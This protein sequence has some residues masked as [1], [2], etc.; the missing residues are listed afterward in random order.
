MSSFGAVDIDNF[1]AESTGL[2]TYDCNPLNNDTSF[3]G[4]INHIDKKSIKLSFCA[5]L[6]MSEESR[7]NLSEI[8]VHLRAVGYEHHFSRYDYDT[9]ESYFLDDH[10]C[11]SFFPKSL[12]F[13]HNDYFEGVKSSLENFVATSAFRNISTLASLPSGVNGSVKPPKITVA[14]TNYNYEQYLE[15]T[16]RS[17]LD[18]NYP[19]V[20]RIIVDDASTDDSGAVIAKYEALFQVV[21]H[22][23]NSGQLAAFFSALAIADGEFTL[24][25]DADDMLDFHAINAHLSVHLYSKPYVAFTCGR[26]RQMSSEG[27]MLSDYHLDLQTHAEKIKYVKPRFMHSPTWSWSTTSAMMFR[28]DMLRLIKTDKTEYFRI[29]ADYYIVNFSNLLGASMIFDTTVSSYRRHGKN[30]FSKNFIIGGHKPTGHMKYHGHPEHKMLTDEIVSKLIGEREAFEPYFGNMA[31]YCTILSYVMPVDELLGIKNLPEDIAGYLRDN[32]R[33]IS[34][35]LKSQV[36]SRNFRL[37]YAKK[38]C[39]F[40]GV[41]SFTKFFNETY[42]EK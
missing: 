42:C 24:F 8:L 31:H 40:K 39:F 5:Y 18:L 1:F 6:A 4:G 37:W 20:Q 7:K 13:I 17:V 11:R 25:V 12:W 33:K 27:S 23:K 2:N 41:K 14:V 3:V 16:L 26:N 29:C 35:E 32:K 15:G 10:L 22:E 36:R 28:T 9:A 38:T 19:Y 30:N 21:R 34:K